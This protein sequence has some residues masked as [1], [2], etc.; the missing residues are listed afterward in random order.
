MV[1]AMLACPSRSLT[2]FT[3]TP[4]LISKV[5]CVPELVQA[6]DR[7]T[8]APGDPLERRG[9][10][11]GVD[12]LAVA[13]GEHPSVE[14]DTGRGCLSE[15]QRSPRVEDRQ[16]RGVEVDRS[17]G[18]AGLVAALVHLVADRDEPAVEREPLSLEVDVLPL[19]PEDLMRRIP[20]MAVSH[21]S[22]KY[23]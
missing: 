10:G 19:E 11:V 8:C 14:L 2:T 1:K 18:V 23:R 7:D 21:R 6:D 16:G 12:R 15:L 4:A 9:D 5:P 17:S 22:G 13:V 3:G 20:V